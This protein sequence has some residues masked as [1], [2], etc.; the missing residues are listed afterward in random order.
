MKLNA[1]ERDEADA[2]EIARRD[3]RASEESG[4]ET[5]VKNE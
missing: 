4:G 1:S 2:R 5:A 3:M